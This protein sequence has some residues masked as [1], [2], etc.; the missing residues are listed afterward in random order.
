MFKTQFIEHAT[1]DLAEWLV[2]NGN[3]TNKA[4]KIYGLNVI[5]DPFVKSIIQVYLEY[6]MLLQVLI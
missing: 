3:D 5:T 4:T 6:R 2:G 1:G